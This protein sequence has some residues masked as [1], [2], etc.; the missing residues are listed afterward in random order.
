MISASSVNVGT[1]VTLIF[2]P[3]S[4]PE[5]R[6]AVSV[7]NRGANVI[8]A[9][10]SAVTGSAGYPIPANTGFSFKQNQSSKIYAICPDGNQSGTATTR[11][12]VET[13]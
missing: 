4:Y 1:A 10:G 11:V 8:F 13:Y 9:G 2:D 3:A 7:H 6:T 12:L 5:G